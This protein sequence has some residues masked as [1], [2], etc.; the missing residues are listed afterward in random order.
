MLYIPLKVIE[1]AASKLQDVSDEKI[2]GLYAKHILCNGGNIEEAKSSVG[3]ALFEARED[4]EKT[5]YENYIY[6]CDL[7]E[8]IIG[9]EELLS[10]LRESLKN[11]D[12]SDDNFVGLR[13]YLTTGLTE[14][15]FDTIKK[16][17]G[18]LS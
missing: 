6:A 18:E 1:F 14:D 4:L 2:Y 13:V 17:G 11:G 16:Q 8:D 5:M 10:M 7:I 9:E 3:E 15:N 12:I